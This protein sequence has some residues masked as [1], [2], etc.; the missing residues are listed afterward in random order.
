MKALAALLLVTNI[1]AY[2]DG[3]HSDEPP[4]DTR[5]YDTVSVAR[6][7]DPYETDEVRVYRESEILR[8]TFKEDG[9]TFKDQAEAEAM[10]YCYIES[11]QGVCD[12]IAS[13]LNGMTINPHNDY[14]NFSCISDKETVRAAYTLENDY[15][16]DISVVRIIEKCE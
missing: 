4:R 16:E 7:G 9:F 11:T 1:M 2:N 8:P 12:E 6:H 15:S 5:A 10:T 13:A 14:S 3:F